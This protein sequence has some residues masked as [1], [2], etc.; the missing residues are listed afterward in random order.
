M[1]VMMMGT[2]WE[3]VVWEQSRPRTAPSGNPGACI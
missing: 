2:G 3:R 1:I